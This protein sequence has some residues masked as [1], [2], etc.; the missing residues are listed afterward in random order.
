MKFRLETPPAVYEAKNAQKGL[1]WALELLI[2]LAL[3]IVI[4]IAQLIIMFPA[5]IILLFTNKAYLTALKTGNMAL[6]EIGIQEVTNSNALTIVMLF[7][8]TMTIVVTLL[9]CKLIQKRKMSSVGF[10]KKGFLKE[11]IIGLLVGFV[12][13]S[14]AVLLCIVTGS[15]NIT[16]L[17]S[18]FSVGIFLLFGLGYMIQGMSE[19]VLCRGYMMISIA[20]RYPLWLAVLLNSL[21]FSALHLGNSGISVLALVNLTLFG[22]F[23]SVY[24]LKRGNIWGIGAIHSIWNFAQGHF[25]GIKVSGIETSCSVLGSVPTEGRSLI[26]GGAFGLEG[27]LAVTAVLVLGTVILLLIPAKYAKKETENQT[28]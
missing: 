15:L 7:A 12:I 22:V 6:A 27:G 5:Q 8:T 25:Y 2:F 10:V 28:T 19:E 13:F 14:A 3:H 20:R 23:A 21:F 1:N 17:S 26:N 9:F 11:Y 4:T 16:G 24:F 18:T